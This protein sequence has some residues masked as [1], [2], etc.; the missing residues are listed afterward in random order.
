MLALAHS[1]SV[2]LGCTVVD[3][4]GLAGAYDYTLTLTRDRGN[5]PPTAVRG[6]SEP[7]SEESG[8]SLF[9]ALQEQLGLKLVAQKQ[10]VEVLW[11]DHIEPPTPN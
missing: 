1:I 7:S 9:T 2:L 6:G 5:A 4:T 3:K 11:I 10:P 8:T